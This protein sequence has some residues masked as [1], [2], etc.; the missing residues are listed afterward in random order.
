MEERS[1]FYR[2]C[3]IIPT[4]FPK[5]IEYFEKSL[6]EYDFDIQSFEERKSK[7]ICIS[8]TNENRLLK[9]AE[10]LKIKKPIKK[11]TQNEIQSLDQRIIDLES[12]DYFIAEKYKEYF[13][14]KEYK[15]FYEAVTKNNKKDTNIKIRYGLDIFTESEMLNL[16]KSI[17]E[18]IPINNKEAFDEL[19]ATE[20]EQNSSSLLKNININ[21]TKKQILIEE[22]SLFNTYI[23][24]SIIKDSFPL[25]ISNFNK[26]LS[27]IDFGKSVNPILIRGYF[28]DELTLYFSWLCHFTNYIFFPAILTALIYIICRFYIKG[29]NADILRIFQIFV[30]TFWT[31]IFIVFWSKKESAFKIMWDNDSK[32][33]D[34]A[35]ERKEY[36]I[37]YSTDIKDN[38][39]KSKIQSY[40]KSFGVTLIFFCI[41]TYFNIV[42]LNIRNLIPEDRHQFLVIQKYKK[43]R[44]KKYSSPWYVMMGRIF[45][46]SILDSIYDS[47]NKSLTEKENH[48]T[49]T[50]Y[51]NSYIIKKF[52]FE[53]YSYFFEIFY[54]SL[55]LNNPV[56]TSRAI[57]YYFYTGKYFRL[58]FELIVKLV[59]PFFSAVLFMKE[60][61]EKQEDKNKKEK[62]KKENKEK[63]NEKEKEKEDESK[64]EIK[65]IKEKENEPIKE[66]EDEPKE[67]IKEKENE[68]KEEIKEKEDEPKE[69]TKENEEPKRKKNEEGNYEKRFLLGYEIDKKEV[70]N[71]SGLGQFKSFSE[72]YSFIKDL[73]LLTVFASSAYLGPILVYLNNSFNIQG[74]LKR[75]SENKRRPEVYKKKNIGAWKY[76]IE[77]IGIMS[78]LT[79]VMFCYS[80]RNIF[81]ENNYF[82]FGE[83]IAIL[84]IIL[85]RIL[86][87][88]DYKWIKT[89]KS[90]QISNKKIN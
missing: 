42:L 71:Q 51:Y 49:K 75:F 28:N 10:N 12:K 78:I 53:S 40:L 18:N 38:K 31:Q 21:S 82:I 46:V 70:L 27:T 25:H 11:I 64:K 6:K 30:I 74:N 36:I 66:K 14:S 48:R 59:V 72:Y 88:S 35:D 80:Y 86:F 69:E 7:Y 29:K 19:I 76:I 43:Q 24:H 26:Q 50:Q 62:D 32:E 41:A 45:A 16:E 22:N 1:F 23:N 47:V 85:F 5:L 67:E 90:R 52:L 8:Q 3:I 58:I 57:K 84:I 34:K 54:V 63:D 4:S 20:Y 33:Y 61:S 15:E 81:G 60:E 87:S 83:I 55:I 56:E 79:N 9:E 73:C 89:Y 39:E 68:P 65:E 2:Y 17:L 77:C 44:D 37:N 13:P